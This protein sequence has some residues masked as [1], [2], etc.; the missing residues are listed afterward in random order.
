LIVSARELIGAAPR[1]R[2]KRLTVYAVFR[3]LSQSFS[4]PDL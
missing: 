3:G 4:A 1:T 2:A